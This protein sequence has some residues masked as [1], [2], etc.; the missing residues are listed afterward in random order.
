MFL[1]ILNIKKDYLNISYLL[2]QILYMQ[3]RLHACIPEYVDSHYYSLKFTQ[4][5]FFKALSTFQKFKMLFNLYWKLWFQSFQGFEHC[6]V[7][8]DTMINMGI[9]EFYQGCPGS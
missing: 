7:L 4:R 3:I 6:T 5:T 1:T 9:V 8:S 2:I